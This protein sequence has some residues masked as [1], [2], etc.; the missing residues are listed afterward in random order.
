MLSDIHVVKDASESNL[1]SVSYPRIIGMQAGAPRDWPTNLPIN[2]W[3]LSNSWATDT[4]IFTCFMIF[5]G[6]GLIE[7]AWSVDNMDY[8]KNFILIFS[9]SNNIT[10][11][12]GQSLVYFWKINMFNNEV[13]SGWWRISWSNLRMTAFIL[14]QAAELW[15]YTPACFT[16]A[17]LPLR[18]SGGAESGH[19]ATDWK[20]P[21]L[22]TIKLLL[23]KQD[24]SP[25]M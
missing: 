20:S 7:L 25:C 1:W 5:P 4:P 6:F 3:P 15:R 17:E 22:E 14:K 19:W 23:I 11:A 18:S 2:R 13:I 21:G 9:N 24:P 8:S 10:S 12:A 16:C